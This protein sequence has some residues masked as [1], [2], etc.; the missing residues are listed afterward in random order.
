MVP[1]AFV[2]PQHDLGCAITGA[3]DPLMAC[4]L[5][6]NDQILFQDKQS[7]FHPLAGRLALTGD[8][9]NRC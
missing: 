9:L 7:G 8:S 1:P 6:E 3:P 2:M 5:S 4:G